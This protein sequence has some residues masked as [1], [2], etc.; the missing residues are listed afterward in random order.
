MT[1]QV[2]QLAGCA[3]TPLA[4][5][6]KALAV[7]RLV[8]EQKDA[9]ARGFWKN[10]AFHLATILDRNEL[11]RFFLNEYVPTPLVAPWNGGSGFYPKDNKSGFEPMSRADAPR[12]ADYRR[13]IALARELVGDRDKR[14]DGDDKV[15]MI[16][17]AR[18]S[19]SGSL[20]DW[21]GAALVLTEGK[22]PL[23]YP[24]LLGTGGND[25]R[26]DFT[27]N[28]MQRLVE[29]FDVDSGA[30]LSGSDELLDAALFGT[31][32]HGLESFSVGQFYPG[33]AGGANASGGFSGGSLV[34]SWD[35]VLML[36]GAVTL[37]V[38]A[39]RRLD[40]HGLA[41]AAA[42][43]AVQSQ[44][45]GYA[46]AAPSDESARGEQW[47]P[48]WERPA[49]LADVRALF[50]EGRMQTGRHRARR[51]LD[52]AR[53]VSL[54]G[55]SRGVT[56]FERF[57]FAERNGQS[58]LA[59]PVGRWP[60]E[61]QPRVR[62]LEEIDPWL[63]LLRSRS[64]GNGAPASLA[65]AARRIESAMFNVCRETRSARWAAL[66]EEIAAAEDLLVARP[67]SAVELRLQPLP[68]LSPEWIVAANDDSPE[69]RLAAAVASQYAP[70]DRK[71]AAEQRLGP[72]RANCLPLEPQH[73]R[74][75][76]ANAHGLVQDPAVVWQGRDTVVDLAAIVL[77]RITD[78]GRKGHE[79]F[80]L[81]GVVP[82]RLDDVDAFLTGQVDTRRLGRLARGLMALDWRNR[83]G[84]EA[85]SAW[86]WERAPLASS[87]S[88][89]ALFRLLYA[90]PGRD[91]V[92]RPDPAPVRLLVGG[93]LED[94]ARAALARLGALGLR[95]KLRHVV[96]GQG[97]AHRLAAAIAFPISSYDRERLLAR[98]ARRTRS[99]GAVAAEVL[100]SP[101]TPKEKP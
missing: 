72:I 31:I 45:E 4:H 93:R 6:L 86:A 13:A 73:F 8:A 27:N 47:M 87:A 3:P 75:F 94:A 56:A 42:P 89:Y 5:Y 100:P 20:L 21:L 64:S 11:A 51:A 37:E 12:L 74:R 60:V 66:L 85:A 17:R 71:R 15:E 9:S 33:A 61:P 24:A 83:D 80:P 40:A 90:E 36:E 44:A 78:A 26:L 30:P 18:A 57:A 1:L 52:A 34:N 55:V 84:I 25:G 92:L 68:R 70:G 14:P 39:V 29:L 99:D 48:L 79:G 67:K 91:V 82:A 96:G 53:A 62:L 54:L 81:R 41:Q 95:P 101:T 7:L 88:L 59:V 46:S 50:I 23:Q 69:F 10:D 2:H 97:L 43:F 19:W 63:G 65:H 35:F 98:I 32:T 76:N 22:R 58:N 38:A 77:R 28:Q 16:R 49:S